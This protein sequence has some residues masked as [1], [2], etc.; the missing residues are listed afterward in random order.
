[1]KTVGG[2]Y[3]IVANDLAYTRASLN[4]HL[5]KEDSSKS[6]VVSSCVKS[7]IQGTTRQK[8]INILSSKYDVLPKLFDI[9][10]NRDQYELW[11]FEDRK[12]KLLE[13]RKTI[14]ALLVWAKNEEK[15]S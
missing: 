13:T 10:P 6:K 14:A 5:K 2:R 9:I 11:L 8:I 3:D 1:M 4:S 15:Q 12:W 7:Q